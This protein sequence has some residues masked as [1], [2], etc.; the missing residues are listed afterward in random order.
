[1]VATV[2]RNAIIRSW[3]VKPVSRSLDPRRHL[4]TRVLSSTA[5]TAQS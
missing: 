2:E 1:M 4:R 5:F 3:P